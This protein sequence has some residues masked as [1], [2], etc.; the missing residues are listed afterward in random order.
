M[1]IYF[2]TLCFS[3]KESS[4]DCTYAQTC[5]SLCLMLIRLISK[6]N[7]H[8]LAMWLI[9]HLGDYRPDCEGDPRHGSEL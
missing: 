5:L 2:Y 9:R 1:F 3:R 6:Q 4:R 8:V 7:C